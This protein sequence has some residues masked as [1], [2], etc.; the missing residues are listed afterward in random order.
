MLY[1]LS[2]EE[3]ARLRKGLVPEFTGAEMLKAVY[4]TDPAAVSRI[5]PRPLRPAEPVALAFVAR[6]PQTNFGSPYMEGALFVRASFRG[7]RGWYCLS[8]PVDDD[9]ALVCGRECYGF[10]KKLAAVTLERRGDVV[11]GSVVRHGT[12]ILRIES[13]PGRAADP[14]D[15]ERIGAVEVDAGGASC[16]L[17]SFNFKHFPTPDSRRF[18]YLPRLVEQT[19]VLRPR[20]GLLEGSARVTV[21]STAYDPLGEVPVV[22]EPL[23]CVYGNWDNTMLPGR[24]V[25]RAWNL[26]RF[27]PHAFF[28]I[29]AATVALGVAGR[30]R[31]EP[32]VARSVGR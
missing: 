32:P 18:D 4:R 19:T 20:R 5:L 6:Y 29:D 22:G 16:K 8:M 1:A 25:A 13:K 15:L 12:E 10:P 31:A 14:G 7:R 2:R 9:D 28:K 3:V 23:V 21:T 30:P 24:V 11:R 27:L 17:T 26:L